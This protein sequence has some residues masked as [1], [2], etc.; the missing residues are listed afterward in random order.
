MAKVGNA[1]ED[2]GGGKV[3]TGVENAAVFVYALDVDAEL[4][5]EDVELGV[6]GEGGLGDKIAENGGWGHVIA[7]GWG[8][9]IFYLFVDTGASEDGVT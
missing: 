8:H 1:L 4:L 5:F 2:G 3:T 7:G 6:E 9:V